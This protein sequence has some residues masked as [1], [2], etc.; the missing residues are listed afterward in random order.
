MAAQ[1]GLPLALAAANLGALGAASG[2][3]VTASVPGYD[4]TEL[5]P[6]IVHIGVGGFHRAH[7][8]HYVHQLCQAG[9][10]DWA[11]VG[12]GILPGDAAM[13]D[14]LGSQDH[15]YTLVVRDVDAVS[16]E[17]VGS[18][19]DYL[20]AHPDPTALVARIADPDTQIVSLTVTEGGYPVDD[21]TGAYDPGSPV[22]GDG[23]AFAIL[24]RGLASRRD[25]GAPP[26]TVLSC[27]NVVGN[28][29][30][31]RTATIGEA[32][33]IDP[34]LAAW[35]DETIAFPNSMVDRITPATTGD[36]RR[37]LADAAGIDDRW[38]VITEP[39]T[40]WVLEDR[41]AGERPPVERLDVVV[42]DDVEPFERMKLRLLNAGHSTLAYV[43]ALIGHVH[44]HDAMGDPA[45]RDFLDGFLEREARPVLP[46]VPGYD[47][48]AFQDGLIARFANPAIRDQIG[49]LCLDG[50]VKFPKFLVPTIQAQLDVDGPIELSALA[51]AAWC[52]YLVGGTAES[53]SPIVVAADPSRDEAMARAAAAE[54]EPATFLDWPAVFG[55]SL[56]SDERF[57][58]AFVDAL[59]RLRTDGVVPSIEAS[60]AW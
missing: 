37:W 29:A 19:V 26:L 18:L 15:L 4:R 28:G 42:T 33:R 11:I 3:E 21:R 43:S 27:D 50:S 35:I 2:P 46:P 9:E 56:P 45:V 39:F 24:A 54:A 10:T 55:E 48:D 59:V 16:A 8:A 57:V 30:V 5:R 53:G 32:A 49:R 40:L 22:A 58:D 20:H 36:D 17:V 25:A 7:L 52:R 12:A 23:S 51:I 13:G 47:V 44:V 34:D 6:S 41:F 1:H 31:T 60:L 14:A 38:P